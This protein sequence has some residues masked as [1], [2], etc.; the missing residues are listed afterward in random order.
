M[1]AGDV[2]RFIAAALLSTLTMDLGSGLCRKLGLTAGAPPEAFAR[3]FG[4]LYRGQV[5]HENVLLAPE[6]KGGMGLA[7]GSH[8]LIG[9]VLTGAFWLA[10]RQFTDKAPSV[11]VLAGLALGYGIF[12]NVFPW[13]FMFPAMGFGFFGKDGPAEFLLLRSSFVNHVWFGLGVFWTT[14]VFMPKR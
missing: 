6:V 13:L 1:S 5:V 12:T 9:T 7:L 14:L 3:W 8:Y 10:L 2:G 11:P 4:H